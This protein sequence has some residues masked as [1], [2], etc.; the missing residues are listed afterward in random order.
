MKQLFKPTA[1]FACMALLLLGA[2]SDDGTEDLAVSVVTDSEIRVVYPGDQQAWVKWV[3]PEDDNITSCQISWENSEG[4]ST[5]AAT[6]SVVSGWNEKTIK[7]I[8]AG[9]Y[10][11]SLV[12][13]T[14]TGLTSGLSVY[15]NVKVY[16]YATY[17]ASL[18]TVT[19]T[20]NPTGSIITWD[21]VHEDCVGAYITYTNS[22][23]E[24]VTTEL[25]SIDSQT[26]LTDAKSCSSFTYEACFCPTFEYNV[27]G[28]TDA[29]VFFVD[30]S[31][32]DIIEVECDESYTFPDAAPIAPS[33]VL[34]CPGT[35]KFKLSWY[36]PQ[37][38]EITYVYIVIE[39]EGF[40]TA[41]TIRLSTSGTGVNGTFAIDGTFAKGVTNEILFINDTENGDI[42]TEGTYLNGAGDKYH[43]AANTPSS[44]SP[45]L[46]DANGIE[47]GDYTVYLYTVKG[48]TDTYSEPTVASIYVYED[49]T[50][51][52]EPAIKEITYDGSAAKVEWEDVTYFNG[53]DSV[54]VVDCIGT[55]VTYFMLDSGGD[56]NG[57]KTTT[58]I[59]TIDNDTSLPTVNG[60]DSEI[61]YTSYFCPEN[62]LD[63][64]YI[65]NSGTYTVPE[66]SPTKPY[67][68]SMRPGSN[69]I[70]AIW[71]LETGD[72]GKGDTFIDAVRFTYYDENGVELYTED[73]IR[74]FL[75]FGEGNENEYSLTNVSADNTYSVGI[76]TIK[77][78]TDGVTVESASTMQII[79][80]LQVYDYSVFE[81]TCVSPYIETYEFDANSCEFTIQWYAPVSGGVID[82]TYVYNIEGDSK[83]ISITDYEN[84]LVL[85][86]LMPGSTYTYQATFSPV[87]NAMDQVT[88]PAIEASISDAYISKSMWA[89]YHMEGDH[90]CNSAVAN[91]VTNSSWN[92]SD[93]WNE[94]Y[95]KNDGTGTAQYEFQAA[96][97]PSGSGEYL[98][99]YCQAGMTIT[100]DLGR[101][102]K[103]SR[104]AIHYWIATGFTGNNLKTFAL[105]GT[106]YNDPVNDE[107]YNSTSDGIVPNLT[108]WDQLLPS[109]SVLQPSM[110]NL[111]FNGDG[112]VDSQ[113]DSDYMYAGLDSYGDADGSGIAYDVDPDAPAI[114]Y[115]KIQ[116]FELWNGSETTSYRCQEIDLWQCGFIDGELD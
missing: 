81:A 87:E 37:V 46:N 103:I 83:T 52:I 64:L 41:D 4:T 59:Q 51:T 110:N 43:D 5:G 66:R 48:L 99:E 71:T 33:D 70:Y 10:T 54:T 116:S 30:E 75:N 50:Y 102:Y 34:L 89:E 26:I 97:I 107:S 105:W 92:F 80:D 57:V 104:F 77:Y 24:V 91:G 78:A 76:Q 2:C 27:Y 86:D 21:D 73:L 63:E 19:A 111:D 115:F 9:T 67:D 94:N 36:T 113:D 13:I 55:T 39:G 53:T 72:D 60:V 11:F 96:I 20:A 114:R 108:K 7:G 42:I 47:A 65:E 90:Y 8:S 40:D 15:D 23:N 68:I 58:S 38:V 22:S 79:S 62:G 112:S 61:T 93:L 32:L 1:I 6:Y 28:K 84:E 82:L 12:S 17:A 88:F 18:P 69:L 95:V 14:K 101:T 44:Y 56:S 29:G 74:K 100:I 109:T 49:G 25:T 106:G 85:T 35:E 45:K 16:D 3:V 98:T 31:G